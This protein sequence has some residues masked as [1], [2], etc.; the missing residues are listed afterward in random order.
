[1]SRLKKNFRRYS[2]IVKFFLHIGVV[3]QAIH[4]VGNADM[5]DVTNGAQ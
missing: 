1:M 4:K 5:R 3:F 2:R